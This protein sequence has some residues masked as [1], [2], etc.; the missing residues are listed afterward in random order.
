[1]IERNERGKGEEK[2]EG[3]KKVKDRRMIRE[4]EERRNRLKKNIYSWKVQYGTFLSVS[5]VS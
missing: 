2:D 5:V 4:R 3:A 1:M